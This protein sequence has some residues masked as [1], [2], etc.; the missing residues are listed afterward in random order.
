MKNQKGFTLI[1][2][3]IVVA[4]IGLLATLAIVSLTSAQ[5]R[6]RDTKRVA[7]A[8]A[9][10]TALELYWNESADYPTSTTWANLA[11][12]LSSFI[13]AMPV[14]PDHDD[15]AVY[16]YLVLDT[17]AP[18]EYYIATT[19]ENDGHSSL[20]Q[21]DDTLSVGGGANAQMIDSGGGAATTGGAATIVCTDPTYC[22]SGSSVL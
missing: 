7:D 1:E 11:S 12:D 4:I 8:K 9:I 19:L 3:L 21:D 20:D 15:G 14:D 18:D 13:S 6:A 22:L 16:E 17:T 10:Q 5:Q 2:L